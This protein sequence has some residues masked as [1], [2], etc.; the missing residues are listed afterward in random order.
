MVSLTDLDPDPTLTAEQEVIAASLSQELIERIDA[1]L[2]SHVR[3][4]G[5]KVALVVGLTMTEQEL[6]VPG[7]PDVYYGQRV[8]LLVKKGVLL[9][10]GN[11]D[12]MRY[13]EVRLP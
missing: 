3:K 4:K 7:L 6:C 13:S 1:N 5:R 9:G 11:L 2:L 12:H 10:H 8:K